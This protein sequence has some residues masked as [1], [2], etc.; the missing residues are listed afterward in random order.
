LRT[1][2][3]EV[4]LLFM[5]DPP[6]KMREPVPSV[7]DRAHKHLRE[8]IRRGPRSKVEHVFRMIVARA[9]EGF[10]GRRAAIGK[11]VKRLRWQRC[12]KTGG[13][14]PPSLR[15]P[16]ILDV[17]RSA[18]RSYTP[19]PYSGPVTIFKAGNMGYTSPMNWQELMT[20]EVQIYEGAGG[21]MDLTMESYV[22]VWAAKLRDAL[23][24]VTTG[25]RRVD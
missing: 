2:G 8:L 18:L 22:G 17:Y 20:G 3:E 12:L 11:R 7:R 4:L 21:H 10:D 6:G 14:L 23:D 1:E 13:L 16:Y 24:S 15:S 25:S 19:Q 5:L 9:R